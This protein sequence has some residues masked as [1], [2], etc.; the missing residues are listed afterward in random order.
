MDSVV[1][2]HL[3]ACEWLRLQP[4]RVTTWPMCCKRPSP[5]K[6][7]QNALKL[8]AVLATSGRKQLNIVLTMI[9]S[10][11]ETPMGNNLYDF[12]GSNSPV[13][14]NQTFVH[15]CS[16]MKHKYLCLTFNCV[17]KEWIPV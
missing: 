7:V 2:L 9:A 16:H 6:A 8:S 1:I 11:I 13:H 4:V 3:V 10:R 5:L 12:S 14:L 15:R 17:V